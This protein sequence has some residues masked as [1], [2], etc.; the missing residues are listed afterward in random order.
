MTKTKT[1]GTTAPAT[2]I[3]ARLGG[4]REIATEL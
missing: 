4:A 2:S 3:G 1:K